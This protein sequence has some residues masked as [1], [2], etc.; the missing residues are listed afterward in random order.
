MREKTAREREKRQVQ[1]RTNPHGL[2]LR[3]DGEE[4]K[5]EDW[6]KEQHSGHRPKTSGDQKEGRRVLRGKKYTQVFSKALKE[7][8]FTSLSSWLKEKRALK[9]KKK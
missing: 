4:K 8:W 9:L 7:H 1:R 3:M 5:E 6:G 2:H